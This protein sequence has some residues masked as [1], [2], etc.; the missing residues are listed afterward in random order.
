MSLNTSSP[1]PP[2]GPEIKREEIMLNCTELDH[3]YDEMMFHAGTDSPLFWGISGGVLLLLSFV[4]L[5]YGERL[6]RVTVAVVAGSFGLI[7]GYVITG[8]ASGV[9]CEIRV[10]V[11]FVFAL[12]LCMIALCLLKV[13]FFLIG[14]LSFGAFAH[15]IYEALPYHQFPVIFM[16]QGRNGIYWLSI[17]GSGIFGA[18][19]AICRKKEFLRVGS[20]MIGGTGIA[21]SIFIFT[22]K[23][24][25]PPLQFPNIIILVCALVATIIGIVVQTYI[26]KK[27]KELQEKKKEKN[28]T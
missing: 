24:A 19:I 12:V 17:L 15:F 7:F 23:V 10:I 6:M 14:A 5:L 20:S 26:E 3:F 9:T 13:G 2:V 8:F 21:G 18:G 16:L 25:S 27:R 22:K 4:L 11:A 1:P 28:R